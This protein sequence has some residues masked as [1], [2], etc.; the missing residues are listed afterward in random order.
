MSKKSKQLSK[1]RARASRAAKRPSRRITD[2][3]TRWKADFPA[4]GAASERPA[5]TE[6]QRGTISPPERMPVN[7]TAGAKRAAVLPKINTL[8][9]CFMF[10]VRL[11][12]VA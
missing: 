4:R 10:G 6:W 5:C 8:V 1:A 7:G 9:R 2:N 3:T 11:R 12:S